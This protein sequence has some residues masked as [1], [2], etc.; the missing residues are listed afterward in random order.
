MPVF[1]TMPSPPPVSSHFEPESFLPCDLHDRLIPAGLV[2]RRGP[3]LTTHDGTRYAAQ[4]AVRIVG[5]PHPESDPFGMTGRVE[6]ICELL[7]RGFVMSAERA[8]LGRQ[9]YDVQYGIIAYPL[10]DPDA[11]GFNRAI[12]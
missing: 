2:T 7:K 6:P 11:S 5:N 8:A 10:A 12:G 1:S 9:I 4:G 3:L